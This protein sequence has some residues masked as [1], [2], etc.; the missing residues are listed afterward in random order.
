MMDV[1]EVRQFLGPALHM[2]AVFDAFSRTPL[3]LQVFNHKPAAPD[4]ARLLTG[5][6][7]AFAAPSHVITD[8]GGEFIG[9]AF[10]KTVRR[11]GA[12]H[13][14]ASADSIK[15]TARLERFWRTLKEAARIRALGLP[16]DCDDLEQRLET[17]LLFYVCFRPHEGLKGATPAEVFLGI[18][19]KHRGAVEPPR[20]RPGERTTA[21]PSRIG[22]LDPEQRFGILK[23]T[24]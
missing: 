18:E 9:A 12:V 13:R 22:Y 17:A 23:P 7:K 14:F 6:V 24:A 15:A 4:M 11:F 1:S 21:A 20:G 10:R 19:P 5:A 8:R 3:A 2:A 16:L